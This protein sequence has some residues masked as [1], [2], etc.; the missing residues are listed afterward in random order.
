MHASGPVRRAPWR[1]IATWMLMAAALA[2]LWGLLALNGSDLDARLSLAV[3][4][5]RS[6]AGDDAMRLITRL[7]DPLLL[8]GLGVGAGAACL[9]RGQGHSAAFSLACVLGVPLNYGIKLLIRQPRPPIEFLLAG[10]GATGSGFP[11]GHAM[12]SCISYGFLAV[13]I[14]GSSLRRRERAIWMALL[15][16]LPLLVGFS[17]VYLGVHWPTDVLGGWLVGLLVLA[18]LSAA[19]RRTGEANRLRGAHPGPAQAS[20]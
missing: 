1:A 6:P 2:A 19:H 9:W 10:S 18:G 3:Q 4:R 12:G 20:R 13:L 17:R 14:G 8:L 16:L 15:I 7:G 5:H 11:S